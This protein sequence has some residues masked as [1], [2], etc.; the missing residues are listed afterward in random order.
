[1]PGFR[2]A[3]I[4][5]AGRG[6]RMLP[7]THV[8]PK[9]MAPC[10]TGTLLAEQIHRLHGTIDAVHVTVGYKA[11]MLASHAVACGARSIVNVGDHGNAWWI[12]NSPLGELDEPVI[13]VTCDNFMDV[14]IGELAI[15]YERLGR[16]ACMLVPTVPRPGTDGDFVTAT[17]D[18]IVTSISRTESSDRYCSGLQVLRPARVAELAAGVVDFTAVWAAMLVHGEVR[19]S[20]VEPTRWIAVDTLHEL[21]GLDAWLSDD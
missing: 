17:E 9:A 2:H 3:V 8:V 1:M 4:L 12:S 21:A 14:P 20:A 18:G 15:E 13:V 10:S 7:L 16:P 5:A 11:E 19:L 6:G